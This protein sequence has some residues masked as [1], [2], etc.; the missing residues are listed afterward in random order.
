MNNFD[1]LGMSEQEYYEKYPMLD[2]ENPYNIARNRT[3]YTVYWDGRKGHWWKISFPYTITYD[4]YYLTIASTM[5]QALRLIR[6]DR[7]KRA[8]PAEKRYYDYPVAYQEEA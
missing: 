6:K 2:P 8:K 3:G 4:G 5:R 7:A 1:L